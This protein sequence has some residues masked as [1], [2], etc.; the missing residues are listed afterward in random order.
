MG[1]QQ[2]GGDR[3]L[4]P[5]RLVRTDPE[6]L[7]NW[8]FEVS[9]GGG[10]G[11]QGTRATKILNSKCTACGCSTRNVRYHVSGLDE[12]LYTQPLCLVAVMDNASKTVSKTDKRRMA[13]TYKPLLEAVNVCCGCWEKQQ[14]S[15]KPWA[16]SH[17]LPAGG[18]LGVEAGGD[19]PYEGNPSIVDCIACT[20]GDPL[21][22]QV[23][24]WLKRPFTYASEVRAKKELSSSTSATNLAS[25]KRKWLCSQGCGLCSRPFP[26]GSHKGAVERH[27]SCPSESCALRYCEDCVGPPTD[28]YLLFAQQRLALAKWA[29]LRLSGDSPTAELGVDVIQVQLAILLT[30]GNADLHTATGYAM[31]LAG[32]KPCDP[33]GVTL[34]PP[35]DTR[36]AWQRNRPN[37]SAVREHC[38]EIGE[39]VTIKWVPR[40]QPPEQGHLGGPLPLGDEVEPEPE[41]DQTDD[42]AAAYPPAWQDRVDN[43]RRRFPWVSK[44]AVVALLHAYDGHAGKAGGDLQNAEVPA[45]FA[46]ADVAAVE[47]ELLRN[48]SLTGA[49]RSGASPE[50]V[51]NLAEM[52]F[53]QNVC[54]RA[55]LETGNS[56][57]AA[58]V[59]WCM[60]HGQ[61]PKSN[62][63]LPDSTGLPA[64]A[65]VETELRRVVLDPRCPRHTPT[66]HSYQSCDTVRRNMTEFLVNDAEATRGSSTPA[67]LPLSPMAYEMLLAEKRAEQLQMYQTEKV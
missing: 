14:P 50:I 23:E 32:V 51:K 30:G 28:P 17:P 12:K 1:V 21:S 49:D 25:E 62:E 61:D 20:N 44:N 37:L 7:A 55:A 16:S 11:R 19:Q 39:L 60:A 57:T 43:L 56:D 54:R 45:G 27:W 6:E 58:A 42:E 34:P 64:G 13:P 66:R 33:R 53:L 63:P 9:G 4:S 41:E 48:L 5:L 59:E 35:E 65:G 52:G 2:A 22:Q 29:H 38:L 31:V 26:P 24:A 36:P 47:K 3:R 8:K 46:A 40:Q 67:L 10:R 18:S 15:S